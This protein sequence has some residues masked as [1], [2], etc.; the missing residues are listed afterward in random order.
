MLGPIDWSADAYHIVDDVTFDLQ[1]HTGLSRREIIKQVVST[2]YHIDEHEF[3]VY[4][5]EIED[6]WYVGETGN[7][8]TRVA[9]HMN[10]R[11]VSNI[12]RVEP[13]DNREDALERERVMSY[14]IA[15]EKNST[16]IYGGK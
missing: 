8:P 14:E 2:Y 6:G 4:C 1:S 5:L 11:N 16:D 7:L 10:K 13:V 15:I 3:H 9:T 12:E